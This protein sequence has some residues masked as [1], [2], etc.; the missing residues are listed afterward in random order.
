MSRPAASPSVWS[1]AFHSKGGALRKPLW[2]QKWAL[3]GRPH[4][5]ALGC[6]PATPRGC[7]GGLCPHVPLSLTSLSHCSSCSAVREELL[8]A[9]F[10]QVGIFVS[11]VDHGFL[12]KEFSKSASAGSVGRDMSS[13]RLREWF[14]RS[15][16]ASPHSPSLCLAAPQTLWCVNDQTSLVSEDL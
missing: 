15:L 6:G 1:G 3:K 7:S 10:R 4:S 13:A 9:A 14:P 11:V 16:S 12:S 8:L 5:C 2:L